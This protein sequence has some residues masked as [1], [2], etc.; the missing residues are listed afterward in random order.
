MNANYFA[1]HIIS[2]YGR[3][4]NLIIAADTFD[5]MLGEIVVKEIHTKG[6]SIEELNEMYV[7]CTKDI[8]YSDDILNFK[9]LCW[10]MR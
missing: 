8:D 3:H 2:C 9:K 4:I 10:S 6:F 5:D 7:T 1:V